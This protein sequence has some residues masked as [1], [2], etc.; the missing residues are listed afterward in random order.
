[1]TPVDVRTPAEVPNILAA[2][3]KRGYSETA[4]ADIAGLNFI[5][6]Y[7]RLGWN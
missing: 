6:Y 3:R 1:V 5:E 7:K 2:L 4:L